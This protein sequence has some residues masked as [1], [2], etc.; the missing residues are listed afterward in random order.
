MLSTAREAGVFNPDK[1]YLA[2]HLSQSRPGEYMVHTVAVAADSGGGG[3]DMEQ[4]F[5]HCVP[6]FTEDD[7]NLLADA[8]AA[9]ADYASLGIVHWTVVHEN[10]TEPPTVEECVGVVATTAAGASIPER[11]VRSVVWK[12]SDTCDDDVPCIAHHPTAL[13]YTWAHQGT[14]VP[15]VPWRIPVVLDRLQHPVVLE[16]LH[17]DW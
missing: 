2:M 4:Y 7:T 12:A 16:R 10:A 9:G 8:R 13:V 15:F 11:R 14:S 6:E 1:Q 5:M 3:Y 17:A